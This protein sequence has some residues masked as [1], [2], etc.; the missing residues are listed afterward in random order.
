MPVLQEGERTLGT[1][2][3]LA[4]YDAVAPNALAHTLKAVE[5]AAQ[6]ICTLADMLQRNPAALLRGKGR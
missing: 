1:I 4:G 3:D 6:S 5:E 2:T